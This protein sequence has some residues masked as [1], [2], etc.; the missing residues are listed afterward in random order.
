MLCVPTSRQPTFA[1]DYRSH[2]HCAEGVA[3]PV[4]LWR[5]SLLAGR[6]S[7]AK[8]V[9]SSIALLIVFGREGAIEG[10]GH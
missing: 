10:G 5:F 2:C 6:F 9:A 8:E 7:I 3:A 4:A 1:L